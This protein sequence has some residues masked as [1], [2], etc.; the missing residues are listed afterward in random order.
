MLM[1]AHHCFAAGDK[2]SSG[3]AK[4]GVPNINIGRNATARNRRFM[5][6]PLGN[7]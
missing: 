4:L 2:F 5:K 7:S 3:A 1:S 6:S